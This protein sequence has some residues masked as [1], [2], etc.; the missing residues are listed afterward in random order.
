MKT[1]II[2]D[3]HN[4]VD[5]V[6]FALQSPV[7]KPYDRVIFLGDYFDDYYDTVQ[8]AANAAQWLEQSIHEPNRIHLMG[9]H[10][11][12]YRFPSN[13]FISASGNTEAKAYAIRGALTEKDWNLLKLF[14]YEQNFLMTHAGVHQFLINWY[15][16]QKKSIYSKHIHII[17]NKEV[18]DLNTQEVIDKII[19]PATDEALIDISRNKSH[20]W[21]DAGYARGG[22]Q[23]VGGIIWLDWNKE[24]EPISD[25]N[26]IVG[27]TEHQFPEQKSTQNSDNYCLDTRNHHI[28]ILEDGKFS[29][30]RT[31]DVLQGHL[32]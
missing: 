12:W 14:H 7:L 29:Y 24:F 17:N 4:R 3:L 10:D 9:T 21:L 13:R 23:P 1:I 28:G 15:V 11:L 22:I 32:I 27:H 5:W 25:L 20:P 6:E 26:Q 19:Q 31:V 16:S 18:L 2:S 30:V 8:N